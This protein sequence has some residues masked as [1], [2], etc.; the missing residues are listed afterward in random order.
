M[1]ARGPLETR[2]IPQEYVY[3]LAESVRAL[4]P[5]VQDDY[6]FGLEV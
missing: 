4:Y 3:K 2:L 6:L 5:A 1:E